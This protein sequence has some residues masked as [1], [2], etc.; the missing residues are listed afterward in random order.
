MS[1]ICQLRVF[2]IVAPIWL[3][4]LDIVRAAEPSPPQDFRA[5]FNGRDLTG[6]HGLNP[7]SVAKLTGE[8]KEAN[9]AQQRADSEN[10]RL[11]PGS[12]AAGA[13]YLLC[14]LYG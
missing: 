7:H 8:K 4:L 1:R 12:R 3:T 11:G 10:I 9:L 6:W 13:G 2:F 14:R 5:I